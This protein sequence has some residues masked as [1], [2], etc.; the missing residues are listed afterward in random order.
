MCLPPPCFTSSRA[1]AIPLYNTTGSKRQG[2]VPL[3]SDSNPDG[4]R[5]LSTQNRFRVSSANRIYHFVTEIALIC[6]SRGLIVAIE[7]P[8]RSLYW[9]TSFFAPLMPLLRFTAHQAC[10]YRS[11]RPKWT[12]VAHNSQELELIN[13]CCPGLSKHTHESWAITPT[14]FAT[15]QETA[16]PLQLAYE[17][18]FAFAKEAVKK[19]WNPPAGSLQPPGEVKYAYLRALV[20]NQPKA[21]KLPPLLSEFAMIHYVHCDATTLPIKPGETL[22]EPWNDVPMEAKLLKQAPLRSKRGVSCD[23]SGK[24]LCDDPG[25]VRRGQD[26]KDSSQTELAFG[27]FRSPEQ[28]V[29]E[30]VAIGHP[31]QL[32]N[33]LPKQ[34]EDALEAM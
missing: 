13:K 24:N 31:I 15:S 19:G 33:G 9:K 30:A 6:I 27:V 18:A 34:L 23:H 21:S 4:L 29:R 14:G 16:Y 5:N 2:P 11:R 10:A 7:N 3:R 1:R 12:A 26:T 8:R 25:K 20:G 17:F 32:E 28:F 22:Q